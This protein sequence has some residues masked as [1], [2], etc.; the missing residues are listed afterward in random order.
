MEIN[1]ITFQEHFCG[2]REK[3]GKSNYIKNVLTIFKPAPVCNVSRVKL[4]ETGT[5]SLHSK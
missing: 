4:I 1:K 3:V 5:L 2:G